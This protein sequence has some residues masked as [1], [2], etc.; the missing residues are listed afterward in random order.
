MATRQSSAGNLKP[1]R[2]ASMRG[3]PLPKQ[4]SEEPSRASPPGSRRR[5][6]PHPAAGVTSGDDSDSDNSITG[7]LSPTSSA[8][9]ANI[10][11]TDGTP[12]VVGKS[13]SPVL[14]RSPLAG[15]PAKAGSVSTLGSFAG[16]SAGVPAAAR[17]ADT[18]EALSELFQT[19]SGSSVDMVARVGAGTKHAVVELVTTKAELARLTALL[20]QSTTAMQDAFS[21]VV[22]AKQESSAADEAAEEASGSGSRRMLGADGKPA[23][24]TDPAADGMS[25]LMDKSRSFIRTMI[26]QLAD[27]SK[28]AESSLLLKEVQSLS[29]KAEELKAQIAEKME[30]SGGRGPRGPVVNLDQFRRVLM[31]QEKVLAKRQEALEAERTEAEEELHKARLEARRVMHNARTAMAANPTVGKPTAASA[32]SDVAVA[33]A[34]VTT[35]DVLQ[36]RSPLQ[37]LRMAAFVSLL[38]RVAHG[39]QQAVALRDAAGA[40]P[41]AS[42]YVYRGVPAFELVA[43]ALL[44]CDD[45]SSMDDRRKRIVAATEE[46][47]GSA[48]QL[49]SLAA[50]S[51][52]TTSALCASPLSKTA[53][54]IVNLFEQDWPSEEIDTPIG[55]DGAIDAER[56]TGMARAILRWGNNVAAMMATELSQAAAADEAVTTAAA[57]ASSGGAAAASAAGAAAGVSEED[58]TDP[59]LQPPPRLPST[60]ADVDRAQAH[61]ITC[62]RTL[63]ESEDVLR[64]NKLTSGRRLQ[65]RIDQLTRAHASSRHDISDDF[66]SLSGLWRDML[67]EGIRR[68]REE[69][70]KLTAKLQADVDAAQEESTAANTAFD[71]VQHEVVT[72]A[73]RQHPATSKITG[74]RVGPRTLT[75]DHFQLLLAAAG[76]EW[77]SGGRKEVRDAFPAHVLSMVQPAFGPP[78][79]VDPSWE[80]ADTT[81]KEQ[82]SAFFTA[83]RAH[84][85]VVCARTI[86][87]SPG[88]EKLLRMLEWNVTDGRYAQQVDAL[89]AGLV[90]LAPASKANMVQDH[91]SSEQVQVP[92]IDCNRLFAAHPDIATALWWGLNLQPQGGSVPVL[93]GLKLSLSDFRRGFPTTSTP[94]NASVL[95]FIR[96][97]LVP[98]EDSTETPEHVAQRHRFAQSSQGGLLTGW[99]DQSGDTR[100]INLPEQ[101]VMPARVNRFV[102]DATAAGSVNAATLA[103]VETMLEHVMTQM[104]AKDGRTPDR[105]AS[106]EYGPY[107]SA[108]PVAHDKATPAGKFRDPDEPDDAD[109]SDL[110]APPAPPSRGTCVMPG[111]EGCSPS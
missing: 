44:A 95:G 55:I 35:D 96:D 9:L 61:S 102:G 32:P 18:P 12:V 108:D 91:S 94:Q 111:D 22:A 76:A 103:R 107:G 93:A 42:D 21:A 11:L 13:R 26:E 50:R 27:S 99:A 23:R 73:A 56:A 53:V 70:A 52:A 51:P 48:L 64:V 38:T 83:A 98:Y 28:A 67:E 4:V 89:F 10:R 15:P 41:A 66:S 90:A 43:A 62:A 60:L 58:P 109:P 57:F 2:T 88:A 72:E 87:N 24:G 19:I 59:E 63:A 6:S 49:L 106:S 36:R 30:S 3:F 45:G 79:E 47:P 92:A 25:D 33:A 17:A 16:P 100:P 74:V 82:A 97:S 46:C 31:E 105:R 77:V 7:E 54:S 14:R 37:V 85:R 104:H 110:V 81:R 68:I 65:E 69:E 5:V 80:K 71:R 8:I 29:S 34:G 75:L 40:V 84:E 20:S 1:G 86:A 78:R 39:K 101:P